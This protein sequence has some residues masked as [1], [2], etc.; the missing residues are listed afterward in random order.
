MTS[1]AFGESSI[2]VTSIAF[3]LHW[4]GMAANSGTYVYTLYRQTPAWLL[5]QYRAFVQGSRK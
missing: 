1:T 3:F 4:Q 2:A 5:I